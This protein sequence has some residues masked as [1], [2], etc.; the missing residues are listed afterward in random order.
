MLADSDGS[1]ARGPPHRRRLRG[2]P[3]AADLEA[4]RPA[5]RRSRMTAT[6]TTR[7]RMRG[8]TAK[9]GVVRRRGGVRT[10]ICSTTRWRPRRGGSV[11]R[12]HVTVWESTQHVSACAPAPGSR[13]ACRS[14]VA[15]ALRPH[16][17]GFGS[18]GGVGKYT[19][20]AALFARDRRP[21]RCVLTREENLAPGTARRPSSGPLG[22]HRGRITAIE[23]ESWSSWGPPDGREPHRPSHG[24]YDVANVRTCAHRV[25]TDRRFSPARPATWRAPALEPAIDG[26]RSR[27]HRPPACHALR[28]I[29]YGHAPLLKRLAECY[30][31]GAREIGWSRRGPAGCAADA[32]APAASGWPRRPER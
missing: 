7:A 24:L 22:L 1:R 6:S 10:P 13:S 19:I 27:R 32:H 25:A 21:V 11:G 3:H 14:R 5:R 29:R 16:G 20:V 17:G 26:L 15:G 4:R 18:K 8:D 28:A 30:E 12:R 31:I 2:P 9:R 23:H